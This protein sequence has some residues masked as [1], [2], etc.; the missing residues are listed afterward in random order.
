[1]KALL[2]SNPPMVDVVVSLSISISMVY[3]A[4]SCCKG[5]S[6]VLRML[7][8][9]L[10]SL[11]IRVVFVIFVA[12]ALA[13]VSSSSSSFLVL[14]RFSLAFTFLRCFLFETCSDLEGSLPL[15]LLSLYR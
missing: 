14:V 2:G 10:S 7:V 11:F 1:M 4:V 12:L 5:I 13:V 9:D 3:A 6:L 8:Y 15:L